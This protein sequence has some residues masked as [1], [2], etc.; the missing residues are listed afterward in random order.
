MLHANEHVV[1]GMH[2]RAPAS[3]CTAQTY[4]TH[5][6]RLS[7]FM[8]AAHSVRHPTALQVASLSA[9]SFAPT[10]LLLLSL[11]LLL[12][13]LLPRMLPA[14]GTLARDGALLAL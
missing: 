14:M 10:A 8:A 9:I 3:P 7:T 6:I 5:P 2:A 11:Q 12:P 13:P 4:R 1:S